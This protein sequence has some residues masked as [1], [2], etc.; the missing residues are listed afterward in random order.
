MNICTH[1]CECFQGYTCTDGT[2]VEVEGASNAGPVLS[3]PRPMY[4]SD[5]EIIVRWHP[6][7][8]VRFN[9]QEPTL[10]LFDNINNTRLDLKNGTTTCDAENRCITVFNFRLSDGTYYGNFVYNGKDA[11]ISL[12][13]NNSRIDPGS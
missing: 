2:C 10:D 13:V 12:Q 8:F 9:N 11:K 3:M 4:T 5:G 6:E 7:G 1:G